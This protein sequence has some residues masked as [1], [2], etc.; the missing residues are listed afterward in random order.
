MEAIT[1]KSK[2]ILLLL[3]QNITRTTGISNTHTHTHTNTHIYTHIHIL[4]VAVLVV[5]LAG[6]RN[7]AGIIVVV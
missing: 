1:N 6:N 4:A 2:V 7:V 3:Y 5:R